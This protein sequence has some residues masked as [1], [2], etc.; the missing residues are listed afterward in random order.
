[1]FDDRPTG[2]FQTVDRYTLFH[3]FHPFSKPSWSF[4]CCHFIP[5]SSSD[6]LPF[7]ISNS[8]EFW[9]MF[10]SSSLPFFTCI[11]Q[12]QRHLTHDGAKGLNPYS[13]EE[14]GKV[15]A[16]HSQQRIQFLCNFLH[17]SS[18]CPVDR[19]DITLLFNLILVPSS[20][21]F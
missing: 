8:C 15:C 11:W 7:A 3:W 16:N 13:Y 21:C 2:S 18:F 10:L 9:V 19:G 6:N 4:S 1:M 14:R 17:L 12:L 20:I 5:P